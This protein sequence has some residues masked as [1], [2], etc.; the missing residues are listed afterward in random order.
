MKLDIRQTQLKKLRDLF[1]GMV[2]NLTCNI[3]DNSFIVY[4]VKDMNVLTPL[5]QILLDP[6][7]DWPTHGAAQALMQYSQQ[8]FQNNTI[9]RMFEKNKIGQQ[10]EE[11]RVMIEHPEAQ[12]HLEQCLV[13][14]DISRSKENHLK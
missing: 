14:L 12:Q 10:I 3:E 7:Q 8:T 6:R 13:Y 4:M 1:I 11:I 9:L 5:L 2:L